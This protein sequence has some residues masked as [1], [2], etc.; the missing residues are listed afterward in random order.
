MNGKR[1]LRISFTV[2]KIAPQVS[3]FGEIVKWKK[4][5]EMTGLLGYRSD[6]K[7]GW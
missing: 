5:H 7:V 4:R 3:E 2:R 6:G 1:L